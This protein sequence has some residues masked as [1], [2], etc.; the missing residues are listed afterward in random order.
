MENEMLLAADVIVK[1]A[2]A[3]ANSI[4]SKLEMLASA[5]RRLIIYRAFRAMK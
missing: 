1:M 2:V 5:R 3:A 4:A